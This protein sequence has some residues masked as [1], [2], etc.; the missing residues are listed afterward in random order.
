VEADL[1]PL[2]QLQ[3]TFVSKR[4]AEKWRVC[5]EKAADCCIDMIE[6]RGVMNGEYYIKDFLPLRSF[7]CLPVENFPEWLA[8][9]RH[10]T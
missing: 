6:S 2:R 9:R 8:L 7:P 5:C 3:N 4:A 10:T 1:T